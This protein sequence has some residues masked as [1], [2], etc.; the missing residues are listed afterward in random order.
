MRT[1]TRLEGS[2]TKTV[3]CSS[4][5]SYVTGLILAPRLL[6]MHQCSLYTNESS[7]SLRSTTLQ[8]CY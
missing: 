4:F 7:V 3:K 6:S 1:R 2:K 8:Y 5:D